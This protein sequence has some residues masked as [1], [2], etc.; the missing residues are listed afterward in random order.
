M[1]D[2]ALIEDTQK[3][4][5]PQRMSTFIGKMLGRRQFARPSDAPNHP[6]VYTRRVQQPPDTKREAVHDKPGP[7]QPMVKRR[8]RCRDDNENLEHD[9]A[10]PSQPPVMRYLRPQGADDEV[11][12]TQ[13]HT[14]PDSQTAPA[15]RQCR[16]CS[17]LSRALACLYLD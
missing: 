7:S 4:S 6:I 15:H 13:Q 9:K 10:E 1:V 12:P 3:V 8:T 16:G 5:I 2:E 11:R 17:R 14:Q